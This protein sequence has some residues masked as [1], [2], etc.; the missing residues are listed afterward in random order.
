ML[1]KKEGKKM[2]GEEI[3]RFRWENNINQTDFAKMAQ[4]GVVTLA[5]AESGKMS[6][7]TQAKIEKTVKELSENV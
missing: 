3:R 4:I 2:T 5:K 6:G 1:T 7:K